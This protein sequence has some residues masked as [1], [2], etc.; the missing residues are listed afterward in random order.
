DGVVL[1]GVNI[2]DSRPSELLRHGIPFA[3]FGRATPDP[4]YPWVDVDE[5]AGAADVIEHLVELGHRR[6]A[7][8][9][10]PL[11]CARAANR[12]EG[13][14]AGLEKHGLLAEC[15][16]LEW[17]ATQTPPAAARVA[18]TLLRL[19]APPTAVVATT[20]TIAAGIMMAQ[21]RCGV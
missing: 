12:V 1:G 9:G 13:W 2:G 8:G 21:S 16:T 4:T 14:G 11:G 10:G 17:H 18:D 7:L 6:I 3:A 15:R 20:D 19:A 5:F